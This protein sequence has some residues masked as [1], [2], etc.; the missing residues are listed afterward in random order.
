MRPF[1]PSVLES[2]L[3][4]PWMLRC[5]L[6]SKPGRSPSCPWGPSHLGLCS[7]SFDVNAPPHRGSPVPDHCHR[8]ESVSCEEQGTPHRSDHSLIPLPGT[9]SLC[10]HPHLLFHT[11]QP[12]AQDRCPGTWVTN[13]SENGRNASAHWEGGEQRRRLSFFFLFFFGP[14]LRHIEVPR[15][16]FEF[17]LQ[18]LAY[19]TAPAMPD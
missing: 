5:S 1:W 8:S 10:A 4:P 15:L 17:E 14:L 2:P 3:C 12:V 13:D 9:R 7:L 6:E 16:G 18:L 11:Q 19:I